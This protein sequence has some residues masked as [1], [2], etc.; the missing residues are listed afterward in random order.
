MSSVNSF[1]SPTTFFGVILAL[2]RIVIVTIPPTFAAYASA[3]RR[4]VALPAL[5]GAVWVYVVS[6][7]S[8]NEDVFV[9]DT[10]VSWRAMVVERRSDFPVW[11]PSLRVPVAPRAYMD[12][13]LCLHRVYFF[14]NA[15]VSA[16]GVSFLAGQDLS[17]A[18]LSRT[19]SA[20]LAKQPCEPDLHVR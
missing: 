9:G 11:I 1:G 20:A 12:I 2:R 13:N 14:A 7:R 17:K 5:S 6:L 19:F 18:W 16:N 3:S 10:A 8:W 15:A 4:R